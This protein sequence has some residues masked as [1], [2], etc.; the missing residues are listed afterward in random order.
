M[1]DFM[2]GIIYIIN[3]LRETTKQRKFIMELNV[4]D[5]M[6]SEYMREYAYINEDNF[7]NKQGVCYIP[8]N[9]FERDYTGKFIITDYYTYDDLL[10]LVRQEGLNDEVVEI[11][12]YELEWE[13]PETYLDN[14]KH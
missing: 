1:L 13:Y 9:G 7:I 14:Y 2:L 11:M 3:K 8:E 12:F 10:E 6:N 5:I 4:K